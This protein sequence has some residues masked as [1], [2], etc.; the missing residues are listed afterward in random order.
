MNIF[1]FNFLNNLLNNVL[2]VLINIYL[3]LE[4]PNPTFKGQLD[5]PIRFSII[6][7]EKEEWT[8]SYL[9]SI[10]GQLLVIVTVN[11]IAMLPFWF[12]NMNSYEN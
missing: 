11:L 5:Q 7:S 12:E 4:N 9:I 3:L 10:F 8:H 2:G 1:Y 6:L